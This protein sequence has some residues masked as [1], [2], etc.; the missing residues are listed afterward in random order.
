MTLALAPVKPDI[1]MELELIDPDKAESY[2]GKNH[3]NRNLR[4]AHYLSQASDMK[5]GRWQSSHMSIAFDTKGKL[6]DGQH[7]LHAI[8]ESGV[9]MWLFVARN[10]PASV[11]EVIDTSAARTGADALKLSGRV[12]SNH[13]AV[14][15]AARTAILWS[16][17]HHRP[18][19]RGV[20]GAR[21]VTNSE[22]TSWVDEQN[23]LPEGA[24]SITGAVALARKWNQV[25]DLMSLGLTS[26]ATLLLGSIDMDDT[27][28]F[29]S[30]L[31]NLEF[32]GDEDPVKQ[33]YLRENE[34]KKS[35]DQLRISEHLYFLITAWNAFRS[36]ESLSKP[37]VKLLSSGKVSVTKL[38]G[39]PNKAGIMIYPQVPD[40]V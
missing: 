20:N 30:K 19:R 11:Q 7:R 2:L 6:I 40:P 1:T 10:V 22:I 5:A 15:S 31:D 18:V 14:A 29:F 35:R 39:K 27:I 23:K 21:K 17:G 36:D 9:S 25:N 33:F 38:E 4:K 26:F 8:V 3:S 13:P 28:K 24:L 34:A 37:F 32:D 16:E 12:D